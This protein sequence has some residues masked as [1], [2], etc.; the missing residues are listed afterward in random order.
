MSN[1]LFDFSAGNSEIATPII[2]HKHFAKFGYMSHEVEWMENIWYVPCAKPIDRI[3]KISTIFST[4]LWIALI[5]VLIATGIT[6]W[7]LARLSRQD[8]AYKNISTALYNTWA[9]MMGVGVTKM[10]RNYYLRTLIFAWISY[11]FAIST[12]FQTFFTSFLVDPGLQKQITSLKEL[13]NSQME[14]GVPP[15]THFLYA[16]NDELTNITDKGHHCHDVK[17]C[18]ER[19]IETGNF[20]VFEEKLFVNM[21]LAKARNRNKVCVMNYYDVDK[22]TLGALFS[23]G[24]QILDQFNKFVTRM[25]QSGEI[26]KHQRDVWK[27]T[28]YIHDEEDMAEQYFVFTIS[29]LLVAFYALAIGHSLGFVILLL[30]LFHHSY[31][32]N[33]QRTVRRKINKRFS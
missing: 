25:L 27:F 6:T 11:S 2:L 31:S 7:Q 28:A 17:K 3:Q 15:G 8:D 1:A 5:V 26:A 24:T 30:E 4:T 9:V 18:V 12:V 29:H 10:P 22:K 14:Y 21:Y 20:A 32:T 33:H 23:R 16:I 19:I 13:S